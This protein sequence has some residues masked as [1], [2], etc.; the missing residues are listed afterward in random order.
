MIRSL[1]TLSACWFSLMSSCAQK[2]NTK[3]SIQNAFDD[4]TDPRVLVWASLPA[5]TFWMGCVPGDILCD[6]T[7]KPRHQV[8]LSAFMIMTTAVTQAQY[9]AVTGHNPS[10]FQPPAWGA[11]PTCPVERVSWQNAHDF[12]AAVGGRLP[13]EAEWEFA[14]RAGTTT[15]YWCG[16]DYHCLDSVAWY[17]N[18]SGVVVHPVCQKRPNDWGLCDMSGDVQEWLNDLFDEHYYAVSPTVDPQGPA[19]S[20]EGLRSARGGGV[21]DLIPNLRA[22]A[23]GG[24]LPDSA[25]LGLGFRCARDVP[26]DDD[27]NDNDV[28][29][30]DDDNDDSSPNG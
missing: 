5:G 14:T 3:Y 30:D 17:F 23:R 6:V 11:C 1:M 10:F 25:N 19:Q 16:D 26:D 2:T 28:S 27:D 7:E 18:N 22:S 9:E 24:A 21:D 13:T 15:I 29:P 12:C 20:D 4:I 8:R